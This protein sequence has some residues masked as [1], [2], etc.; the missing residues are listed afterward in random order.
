MPETRDRLPRDNDVMVSYSNRRQII[1]DGNRN[2][3]VIVLVDEAED[4]STGTPFRW[5]GAPMV[6]THPS[7]GVS[8][9]RGGLV[10]PRFGR[11]P[12]FRR[13]SSLALGRENMYP[14]VGSG[15]GGLRG[16]GSLRFPAW[17]PRKP[18]RDITAVMRAIDRRR[19]RR[20][21]GEGLETESPLLQDQ[22]VHDPS[23]STS[24]AQLEQEDPSVTSPLATAGIRCCPPTVGK[25]PKILLN[26]TNQSD[27]GSTCLTPQKKL[28]NNIE[29]V[30]REVMEELHKLKST[31][32]AKKA[33]RQKRVRTLMSMC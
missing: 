32:S 30:E 17:Y 6:G 25:V 5:R 29:A 2:P 19:A 14:V 8:R 24:V 27:G 26:V 21:E 13:S 16:R 1:G 15:R 28:L 12:N 9:R 22:I 10:S 4:Q 3:D 7:R 23:V 11:S 33:E 31:P 18:L 20:D